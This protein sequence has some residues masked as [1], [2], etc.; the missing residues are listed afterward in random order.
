MQKHVHF[1]QRPGGTDG[2]LSEQGV[3]FRAIVFFTNLAPAF[4]QQRTGTTGRVA[5]FVTFLR[6]QQLSDKIRHFGRRVKL[7]GF[8]AR[9]GGKV[10]DQVFIGIADHIQGANARGSQVQ[11]GFVEVFQ[12]MTQDFIF[13]LVVSQLVR[14]EANVLKHI[15]QLGDIGFLNGVQRLVDALA[16]TRLVAVFKQA[17]ETGFLWQH[18]TLGLHQLRDQL[19]LVPVLGLVGVVV[20]LPDIADVF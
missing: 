10:F 17:V 8:F 14:V 13:L 11:L 15:P 9:S 20:V 18:K 16:V 6:F 5:D 19:R 12:Y 7:T 4:H 1:G 3:F 2:F